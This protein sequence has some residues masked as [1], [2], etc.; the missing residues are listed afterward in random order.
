MFNN[1]EIFYLFC[2]KIYDNIIIIII[3]S[4]FKNSKTIK[5]NTKKSNIKIKT[6]TKKIKINTKKSK[7]IK[8]NTKKSKIIKINTKKSKIINTNKNKNKYIQNILKKNKSLNKSHTSLLDNI[9]LKK[10]I[11]EGSYGKVYLAVDSTK[12]NMLIKLKKC[13]QI[14]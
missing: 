3:M 2:N 11:G 9:T 10:K 4:K 8:I 6:N 14:K 7:I 12:K 1:F 13:F 5:T